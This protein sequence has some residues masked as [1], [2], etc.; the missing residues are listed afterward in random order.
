M[1]AGG[2]SYGVADL[3]IHSSAN[4][5]TASIPDILEFVEHKTSLNIIAITDHDEIRGSYEARELAAQHNYRFQVVPGIEVSTLDGHLLALFIETPVPK[6]W[7]LANTIDA[8]H[9]QGGICIVPHPMSWLTHSVGQ[10]KLEAIAFG[11]DIYLD[12][13]ETSNPTIAARVTR[14]KAFRLNREQYH[15]AET[16]GS[17]AHSL[18]MIGRGYTIFQGS[19]ANDLKRAILERTTRADTTSPLRISEM[20][21]SE[22]R[23]HT[24]TWLT[25]YPAYRISAWFRKTFRLY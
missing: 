9:A 21:L 5:G 22:L 17:D 16:G 18:S 8:I 12:G 14:S 24:T 1:D 7:P 19:S 11:S 6:F 13:I 20:R 25:S 3:H 2:D 10:R 23:K 15:L 4:D